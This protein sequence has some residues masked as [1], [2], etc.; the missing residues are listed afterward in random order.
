MFFGWVSLLTSEGH[1]GTLPSWWGKLVVIL[2]YRR[3]TQH[4][5]QFICSFQLSTSD[6]VGIKRRLKLCLLSISPPVKRTHAEG[7]LID[8]VNTDPVEHLAHPW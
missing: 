4:G 6:C 3:K 7:E 8:C 5:V 1:T 2:N